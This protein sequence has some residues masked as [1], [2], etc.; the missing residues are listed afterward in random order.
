MNLAS[1]GLGE[2]TQEIATGRLRVLVVDDDPACSRLVEKLLSRAG[3]DVL[4]AVDGHAG[5]EQLLRQRPDVVVTDWSMP[6]MDGIELI[7]AIRS[8]DLPWY[9]YIILL[10]ANADQQQG[11]DSGA[12]DF[13]VKPIRPESLLPRVRAGGRIVTLQAQLRQKNEALNHANERLAQLVVTDPLTGLLNRRAFLEQLRQEWLR[14]QRYNT[15]LSAVVLDI[16]HFKKVNDTHGHPAGD[17]VIR[18]VASSLTRQ[19]RE[20]DLICRYGGEEFCV[21]LINTT[22]D[23]ASVVAERLRQDVVDTVSVPGAPEWTITVSLGVAGRHLTTESPD[24]LIDQADQ[25]L[26]VAKRTGR[27]RVVRFDEAQSSSLLTGSDNHGVHDARVDSAALIPFHVVNTLFTALQFRDEETA[28]HSRRVAELCRSFADFLR[29]D[30]EERLTLEIAALMHDVGKLGLPDGLLKK[31]GPLDRDEQ[32]RADRHHHMAIEIL[33]ACFSN[34]RL[35]EMI[36][37]ADRWFDGSHGEPHGRAI[38][39]GARVLAMINLY[40]DLMRG[41]RCLHRHT[42]EAAL[43]AIEAAAGTQLDPDLVRNFAEMLHAPRGH[44]VQVRA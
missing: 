14:A 13:I 8:A 43:A 20:T 35:L 26:L 25:A 15:P 18:A 9:P 40:D 31:P 24:M 34:Q 39:G 33:G 30:P 3:H 42:K 32:F 28:A 38:P 1:D 16:D 10:T 7:R 2:T 6:G 44:D 41:H 27:N 4:V 23:L 29:L 21:L 17:D 19:F 22:L 5:Y 36:G 37:T 12:D 11:L